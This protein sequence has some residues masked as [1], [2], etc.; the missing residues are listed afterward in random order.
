MREKDRGRLLFRPG[1]EISVLR[2][3]ELHSRLRRGRHDDEPLSEPHRNQGSI[4][5]R[6]ARQ[7]PVWVSADQ[8]QGAYDRPCKRPRRKI[9]RRREESHEQV[10]GDHRNH[11]PL[12]HPI[13]NQFINSVHLS[14]LLTFTLVLPTFQTKVDILL[15]MQQFPCN[16]LQ[17]IDHCCL[18][19]GA[20]IRMHSVHTPN[21]KIPVNDYQIR[22]KIMICFVVEGEAHTPRI[23]GTESML[24]EH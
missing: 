15:G 2:L 23:S 7:A 6:Q 13:A 4:L 21:Y 14:D 20:I 12:Q 3:H 22:E 17:A 18:G 10:D 9:L 5:L 1:A 11:R 19:S 16:S 24:R 8:V